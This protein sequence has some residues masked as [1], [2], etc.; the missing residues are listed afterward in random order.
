MKCIIKYLISWSTKA[1]KSIPITIR[2]ESEGETA[3]IT[4]APISITTTTHSLSNKLPYLRGGD[5][6]KSPVVEDDCNAMYCM[7]PNHW[8]KIMNINF[9]NYTWPWE[10]GSITGVSS[11]AVGLTPRGM[12]IKEWWPSDNNL[13]LI[14][15]FFL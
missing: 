13:R 5:D 10:L 2:L 11:K 1:W 9:F 7:I 3:W 14:G 15:L 8:S 12:I 4:T 6:G